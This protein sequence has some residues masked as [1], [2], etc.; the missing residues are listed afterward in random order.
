MDGLAADHRCGHQ[1]RLVS[2]PDAVFSRLRK[3]PVALRQAQPRALLAAADKAKPVMEHA[4]GA[5]QR[6][7]GKSVKV[8]IRKLA[9]DIVSLK[10]GPPGW[11]RILN[12]RTAP[13]FIG[14]RRKGTGSL[15]KQNSIRGS[16]RATAMAIASAL[17][18]TVGA[19]TRGGINIKGVGV[20]AY[21]FHPGTKGK[22]FVEE[23]KKRA[24]PVATKEYASKALTE[25]MRSVFHG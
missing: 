19:G 8:T 10:W 21:A 6:V 24:V 7:D 1:R 25:P 2:T 9:D 4:P 17:G 14:P 3:A 16:R 20:R 12:D 23:G 15:R 11:V 5:A 18:G 13:H 22:H